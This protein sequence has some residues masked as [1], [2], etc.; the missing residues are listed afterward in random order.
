MGRKLKKGDISALGGEDADL[1]LL[2]GVDSDAEMPAASSSKTDRGLA[3]D[4]SKFMKDLKLP[5]AAEADSVNSNS[6][7]EADKSATSK[8]KSND[9]KPRKDGADADN[10]KASP[11]L[12]LA[13]KDKKSK[14]AAKPTSEP[15]P[16]TSTAP[17]RE[18]K[19]N[20]KV[21]ASSFKSKLS[22]E[23]SSP[24]KAEKQH[25]R[26][27]APAP[28]DTKPI[29]S[30][31][32][33]GLLVPAVSN[34]YTVFPAL[35]AT[36]K[37]L[38]APTTEKVASLSTHAASLLAEDVRRYEAQTSTS[39]GA[40]AQFLSR[41]LSTGTLSD[42]LSAL[43]LLAQGSPLHNQRALES[44]KALAQKKSRE[45]SLKALRAIADWWAGGGAPDRKLKYFRDQP[46]GHP[47][48][49]DAHLVVW[50][51]EDWLK[52]YFYGIL[53][54]LEALS[55]D[56]L[57]YVR[58]QAVTF[59]FQLLRDKPEQ[60]QNLLRLLVNKLGDTD[61]PVASRVSYQLMQ[62]VQAHPQMKGIIISEVS[63]SIFGGRDKDKEKRSQR[64][65]Y[66]AVITFNQMVLSAREGAVADR[67]MDMYFKLFQEMLGEGEEKEKAG[68]EEGDE[69]ER[70]KKRRKV[71]TK[72]KKKGKK[73]ADEDDD[74]AN[75]EE[76]DSKMISAILTG[77][78]R[79]LPFASLT[80][81]SF[82]KHIDTLFRITHEATFNIS[83]QALMLI[84]HIVSSS[85]IP[86]GADLSNRFYRTLYA[87]LLDP[88]LPGSGKHALF[89]TLLNRAMR[90]D[91]ESARRA[92]FVRRLL[93]VL[94]AHG[95]GFACAAL[96]M[97]GRLV[98]QKPDIR[99]MISGPAAPADGAR[100]DPAK[101]EP[102]YAH[103]EGTCLWELVPLLHH[104]HPSVALHAQQ[105]RDGERLTGA[106]DVGLYSLASF[107]DRFVLKNA[108]KKP[109]VR[110]A[111]AMQPVAEKGAADALDDED[112]AKLDE[113][114]VAP[115]QLFYHRF[116][117]L[118]GER[119]QKMASKAGKRK[120]KGEDDEGDDVGV[121]RDDGDDE[122]EGSELDED[123]V[124]AA[125][126]R[127]AADLDVDPDVDE[128]S[129][130]EMPD[131]DEEDASGASQ[132]EEDDEESGAEGEDDEEAAS[133]E[134]ESAEERPSDQEDD[135]EGGMEFMEED[136]DVMGDDELIDLADIMPSED[137]EGE[138]GEWGGIDAA[139]Q[140]KKRK[141][142]KEEETGKKKKKRLRDLPTFATYEDYER[143]IDETPE[144]NI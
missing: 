43:T 1:D 17:S 97:L 8:G 110:G 74:F 71:H 135:S 51:F 55:M 130:L 84:D 72:D 115:D 34:W 12:F 99:A 36:A 104:Y 2:N 69:G 75:L 128:D 70:P 19:A 23:E 48:A 96:V 123:E 58:I 143:M 15:A 37:P 54:I 52:K 93:Q 116:V 141:R 18:K 9:K 112:L 46:L 41:V 94:A 86:S 124:W 44:L 20:K 134:D 21:A 14:K 100:Y 56:P 73:G 60:E 76:S 108:K 129:D 67:L 95:P 28:Q 121:G 30:S 39:S 38:P 29:P 106:P 102:L 50:Y 83:V 32:K 117:K 92:A 85:A 31:S 88:R 49:T 35:P 65:R 114:Q 140:G 90:R 139:E 122:E 13:V 125:M 27:E 7:P 16:E 126:K 40:D 45:Q 61:R 119:E 80:E 127:S 81:S 144:D 57:P 66:Y 63:A 89:L 68:D 4:L 24:A 111:S 107:L 10:F 91:A 98:Q 11:L 5:A 131:D 79:A 142:G 82:T 78:N 42:R 26:F 6:K 53:Q 101:R 22:V 59:I 25:I 109:A 103:A 138:E 113:E 136:D 133:A 3:K 120:K 105:L 87:A 64:A 62:L 33:G 118:K 137:E 132:A 77:I 47:N